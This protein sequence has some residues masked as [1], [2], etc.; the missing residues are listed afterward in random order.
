MALR[1]RSKKIQFN[2]DFQTMNDITMELKT[3]KPN[4]LKD[5]DYSQNGAYFIMICIK[6][7]KPILSQIIV[8]EN[9]V[10]PTIC[11][12]N[13]G[14]TIKKEI[15]KIHSIYDNVLIDNYI[16]MPNHI[17][18]II[19]IDNNGRTQ[20]GRTQFSPTINR[21]IKQFKGSITKQIGKS[22]W[23][24]SFYDHIIRD[25]IDYQ[26]VWQY[27]DENPTKWKEDRLYVHCF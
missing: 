20:Y 10:L 22:I 17:H 21:I 14:E 4:R 25:E 27:I 24:K 26:N 16:I 6:D 7:R 19:R 13:V 11:L 9:C 2:I 15:E 8:G 5:Y 23:Q 3:R 18:L 12:T 1:Q